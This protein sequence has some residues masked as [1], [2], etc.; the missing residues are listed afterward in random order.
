MLRVEP[1]HVVFARVVLHKAYVRHVELVN[2]L[3]SAVNVTVKPSAPSR[4]RI[5]PAAAVIPPAGKVT[6]AVRLLLTRP[7]PHSAASVGISDTFM[8]DGGPGAFR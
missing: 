7:P 8:I 1:E 4:Y 2:T 5:T 6:F 3:S